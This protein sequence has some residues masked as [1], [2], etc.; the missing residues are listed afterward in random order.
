MKSNFVEDICPFVCEATGGWSEPDMWV[1]VPVAYSELILDQTEFSL[2]M[3]FVLKSR[4]PGMKN[5]SW[6]G[7]NS[8]TRRFKIGRATVRKVTF[9][10][11]Y[12]GLIRIFKPRTLKNPSPNH[13][14]KK[15]KSNTYVYRDLKPVDLPLF[16]NTILPLARKEYETRYDTQGR[17]G[18][19]NGTVS[20][21]KKRLHRGG[22]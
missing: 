10:L 6:Y 5:A 14:G 7:Y 12:A 20:T 4:N 17:N 19:N 22:E 15:I 2:L 16:N 13:S 11:K 3:F 18:S 1:N 8:L 21:R 9:I